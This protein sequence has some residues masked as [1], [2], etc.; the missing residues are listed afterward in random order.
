MSLKSSNDIYKYVV[1]LWMAFYAYIEYLIVGRK[2]Q[3]RANKI[4]LFV[5]CEYKKIIPRYTT[6]STHKVRFSYKIN[7]QSKLSEHG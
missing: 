7:N 2:V 4:S 5:I 6:I 3:V 1:T